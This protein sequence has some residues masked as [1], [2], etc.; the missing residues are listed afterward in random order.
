MDEEDTEYYNPKSAKKWLDK[1]IDLGDRDALVLKATTMLIENEIYNKDTDRGLLILNKEAESGNVYAAEV[2]AEVAFLTVPSEKSSS[3]SYKWGKYLFDKGHTSG[4]YTLAHFYEQGVI[5]YKDCY[6]AYTYS[7]IGQWSNYYN[8]FPYDK[9]ESIIQKCDKE[10]SPD[11]KSHA[12]Q[13]AKK[14][15]KEKKMVRQD[16]Q[17]AKD[18]EYFIP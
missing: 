17:W 13:E 12:I 6:K 4:F 16:R 5:V 8:G 18:Y 15:M 1:A 10:L 11:E 7:L 14:I 9:L 2:L 3:L